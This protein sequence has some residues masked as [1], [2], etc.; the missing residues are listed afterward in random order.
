MTSLARALP[1]PTA[2]RASP[3]CARR[4]LVR[5]CANDDKVDERTNDIRLQTRR[6]MLVAQVGTVASY[7]KVWQMLLATHRTPFNSGFRMR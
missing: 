2:A 6:K 7:G 1:A 4:R 5:A 3:R